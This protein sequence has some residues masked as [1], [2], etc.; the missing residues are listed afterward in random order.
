M[1][2]LVS[3]SPPCNHNKLDDTVPE[4]H[5]WKNLSLPAF[6]HG[7]GCLVLWRSAVGS[8]RW[9]RR[10]YRTFHCALKFVLE[11]GRC[12]VFEVCW[13]RGCGSPRFPPFLS[14]A[15]TSLGAHHLLWMSLP[16]RSSVFVTGWENN[17]GMWPE[18]PDEHRQKKRI[19]IAVSGSKVRVFTLFVLFCFLS[20]PIL[21][22]SP[23]INATAFCWWIF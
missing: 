13:K 4:L 11:G 21:P 19:S 17:S 9:L 15:A 1:S 16:A 2:H 3:F 10:F 12:F 14:K 23:K 8:L 5:R 18:G 22:G 6:W 7:R 20:V